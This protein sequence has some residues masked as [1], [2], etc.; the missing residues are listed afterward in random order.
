MPGNRTPNNKE[1]P[2][3]EFSTPRDLSPERHVASNFASTALPPSYGS[4]SDLTQLAEFSRNINTARSHKRRAYGS[5]DGAGSSSTDMVAFMAEIR[6]LI[7]AVSTRQEEQFKDIKLAMEEHTTEIKTSITH[8]SAKYDSVITEINALKEDT[9]VDRKRLGNL[10]EK[11]E[12]LERQ[13]RSTSLEIRNIPIKDRESTEELTKLMLE[14]SNTVGAELQ[15]GEIKDI[16]TVSTGNSSKTIITELT[17]VPAKEKIINAYKTYNKN[18][19]KK[20]NTSALNISG[21]TVPIYISECLTSKAKRL[22]YLAR[23]FKDQYNYKYCWTSYGRI[24][25][26]KNDGSPKIRITE[27]RDLVDLVKK[28]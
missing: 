7:D 24:F 16:F 28:E 26:R 17:T 12:Q 2:T 9:K 14:L 10:E 25:L 8:L 11:I 19:Q 6:K 20:L 4:E 3:G 22:F 18:Q 27:E 23:N 21:P 13:T 1:V 5:P 15:H